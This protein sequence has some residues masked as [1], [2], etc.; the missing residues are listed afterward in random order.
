MYAS[1]SIQLLQAV[2]DSGWSTNGGLLRNLMERVFKVCS[3]AGSTRACYHAWNVCAPPAPEA[4][5]ALPIMAVNHLLAAWCQAPIDNTARSAEMSILGQ[6]PIPAG[7]D[8]VGRALWELAESGLS[9]RGFRERVLGLAELVDA[10]ADA[11]TFY[12]FLR[13]IAREIMEAPGDAEA[14]RDEAAAYWRA[15]TVTCSRGGVPK[16]VVD[17]SAVRFLGIAAELGTGR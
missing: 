5:G 10:E 3:E 14:L 17:A 7:Q 16:V 11:L 1:L 13:S 4:A 9:G 8:V 2:S 15:Q 6:V 12:G